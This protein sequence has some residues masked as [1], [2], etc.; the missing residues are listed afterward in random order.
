[1]HS[2]SGMLH[3]AELPYFTIKS[4]IFALLFS[5]VLVELLSNKSVHYVD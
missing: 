5:M 2:S 3:P 4:M 1:M